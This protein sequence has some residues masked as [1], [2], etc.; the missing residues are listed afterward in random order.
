GVKRKKP[1]LEEMNYVDEYLLNML[2]NFP[3]TVPVPDW[4][5]KSPRMSNEEP[6]NMDDGNV[7]INNNREVPH[8]PVATASA[9]PDHDW[10]LGSCCW[11]NLPSI[12]EDQS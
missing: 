11:N 7:G 9:M 5:D 10:A 3:M 8:S 4:D 2:D 6:W 1:Q 12:C